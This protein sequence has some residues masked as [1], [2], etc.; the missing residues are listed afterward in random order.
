MT[1]WNPDGLTTT[2]RGYGWQWQKLREQ[3]LQRDMHLCQP[4]AREGRTTPA[5]QVD[6]IKPKAK[7]GTEAPD[8][9]QAICT[10]CHDAK[11]AQEA[12][13]GQ[14]REHRPRVTIGPDG[15]PVW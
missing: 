3:I 9:L 14:G 7:G 15:W 13:D 12:A 8:N 4:C 5:R 6:H 1:R 2:E 11:S 10:P